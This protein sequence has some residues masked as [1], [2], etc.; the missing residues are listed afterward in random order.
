MIVPP[1]IHQ[2]VH[3]LSYGDA[4]STEVVALQRA[5]RGEG[6]SSEIFALHE[7]PLLAGMT[8]PLA[9][10]AAEGSAEL[11]LHYSLGSPLNDA[12]RGWSRG[13]RT[14]V[15]H[16]ITPAYWFE[17]VNP[18]VAAD[19]ARGI[20]ELPE[21]CALSDAV[22]ADSSFNAGELQALGFKAEVLDLP[23]EPT[24]WDRPRNAGVYDAL[25]RTEGIKVLHVGR[26]AP[27]KCIEDVIASFAILNRHLEPRSTLWL[28]GIDTDTELYSFRLRRLV[29]N[30]GLEAQ[31]RF[32]GGRA[33]EELRALYEG[34]SVYLCM[35]EHEGFCLPLIEAMHF[36]LPVVA[37]G[38]GAVPDTVGAGGIVVFEKRYAEVAA[39][40][41]AVATDE[42]LRS[43]LVRRGRERVAAFSFDRFCARVAQLVARPAQREVA[44]V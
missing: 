39:L 22:W 31:V 16:N 24:R 2:L 9:A 37:F 1:P 41:R 17:G 8:R 15:Y 11:V 35:S 14:L 10:L 5:L 38:A 4:I 19:I 3:T 40:L 30:L 28:A 29:A 25:A 33:D 18:R 23:I 36:G 42:G 6:R 7:H 13:R 20:A 21:L 43:E 12:Y 27:N 26:I 34:C 44:Q 32:L